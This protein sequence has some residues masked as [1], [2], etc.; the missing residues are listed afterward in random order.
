[1]AAV[2]AKRNA[3]VDAKRAAGV[4]VKGPSRIT[5]LDASIG[6]IPSF[7]WSVWERQDFAQEQS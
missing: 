7:H 6:R 3:G 1:M 2:C 4:D 5:A